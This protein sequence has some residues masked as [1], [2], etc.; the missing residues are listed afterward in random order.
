MKATKIAIGFDVV[1][2]DED[3]RRLVWETSAETNLAKKKLLEAVIRFSPDRKVRKQARTE[4]AEV[5]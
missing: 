4:L 1:M 3:D 2:K 5:R